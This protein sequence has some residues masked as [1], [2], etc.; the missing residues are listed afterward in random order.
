MQ[1]LLIKFG[2]NLIS[3]LFISYIKEIRL[4]QNMF[5]HTLY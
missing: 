5:L 1:E 3:I 4:N 2:I